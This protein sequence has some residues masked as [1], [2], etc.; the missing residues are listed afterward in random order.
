MTG[1]TFHFDT[2]L[3]GELI[4]WES[5]QG[6]DTALDLCALDPATGACPASRVVTLESASSPE[7]SGERLVWHMSTPGEDVDVYFCERDRLTGACPAQRLTSAPGPQSEADID[8][9]WVVW[10]DGRAGPPQVRALELPRLL[11][12]RDQRVREGERLRLGLFARDP[13]GGAI[14]FALTDPHGAPL[15]DLGIRLRRPFARE[16]FAMLTWKPGFAAAGVYA[17]RVEARFASG[18][19]SSESFEV[20]VAEREP[21]P[22]RPR[23][24]R[25]WWLRWW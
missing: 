5:L 18:L 22:R 14:G 16:G 2:A 10:V 4:A 11:P 3:S 8:G 20:H 1:S 7:L 13:Q 19:V 6:F 12:I 25:W 17:L 9:H 24:T 21:P 15:P 23:W